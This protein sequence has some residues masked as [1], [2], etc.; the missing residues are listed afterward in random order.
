MSFIEI[1]FTKLNNKKAKRKVK[2]KNVFYTDKVKLVTQ[3]LLHKT[4]QK[5]KI[6][7]YTKS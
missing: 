6:A 7:L 4:R 2:T 3:T 5:Q 1:L